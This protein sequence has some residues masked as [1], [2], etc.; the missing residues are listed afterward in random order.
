MLSK[1]PK[2]RSGRPQIEE[3][4]FL[5]FVPVPSVELNLADPFKTNYTKEENF[6]AYRMF[7]MI[8]LDGSGFVTLREIE[9]ILMGL[10]DVRT[11]TE[12]FQ[13][14]DTGLTFGLG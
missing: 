2:K 11:L 10:K 9:R 13:D 1:S 4:N 5:T 8:D 3:D 6:R 14:A 7:S 12:A